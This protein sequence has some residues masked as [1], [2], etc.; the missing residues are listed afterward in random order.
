MSR[1]DT[2]SIPTEW[3]PEI[4]K[5]DEFW[6]AISEWQ[7]KD[8]NNEYDMYVFNAKSRQMFMQDYELDLIEKTNS[9]FTKTMEIRLTNKVKQLFDDTLLC[10]SMPGTVFYEIKLSIVKGILT[11]IKIIKIFNFKREL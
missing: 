3:L 8:L 11:D 10:V 7:T 6:D 5:K 2:I 4:I 9:I 1:Y